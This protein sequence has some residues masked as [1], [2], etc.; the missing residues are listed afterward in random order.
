MAASTNIKARY[1]SPNTLS[2]PVSPE[3]PAHNLAVNAR[4]DCRHV[5]RG[6]FDALRHMA[7]ETNG[8]ATLD[9]VNSAIINPATIGS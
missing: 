7:T 4:N 2:A 3:N 6:Y 8:I 5:S 1:N 9:N